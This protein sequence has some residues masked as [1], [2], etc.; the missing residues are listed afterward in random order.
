MLNQNSNL[1]SAMVAQPITKLIAVNAAV[2]L[3]RA[4]RGVA[5]AQLDK[6]TRDLLSG[7]AQAYYAAAEATSE[8]IAALELQASV[9]EQRARQAGSGTAHWPGGRPGKESFKCAASCKRFDQLL[10][11]LLNQPPCTVYELVDPVPCEPAVR[12]ADEAA[13]RAAACNP[14]VLEALQG[15]AKAEAAMRIARMAYLPDLNVMGG[16]ANQTVANYI[17]PNIGFLGVTAN[18]TF[19]EWGKRLDVKRQRQVDLA[20]ANQNVRVVMD[21][22]QLEAR[23]AFDHYAQTREEFGLAGEMVQARKDAENAAAGMAA[24][25]AK[26]DTSKA[27]LEQMKA[28]IAYRV[29][30][31]QLAA[32]VGGE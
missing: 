24:L 18:Y 2:Q 29:A 5:Q 11:D 16:Y 22:I 30:H 6:G 28:E 23:K 19:F 12:C 25:Q 15:I 27:E 10:N 17:Q 4:D 8:F 32:I 14:E 9:L 7:V 3:A 31:A 21:K 20:M 13:Q 26:A 1:A